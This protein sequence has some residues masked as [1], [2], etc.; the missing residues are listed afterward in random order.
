MAIRESQRWLDSKDACLK[1]PACLFH[2]RQSLAAR[3]RR[4]SSEPSTHFRRPGRNVFQCEQS[5]I[6]D[7]NIA[8]VTDRMGQEKEKD[9]A[10]KMANRPERKGAEAGGVEEMK[11]GRLF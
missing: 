9:D 1:N 6:S 5:T 8:S 4:R 7:N 2:R 11:V 3:L 10:E